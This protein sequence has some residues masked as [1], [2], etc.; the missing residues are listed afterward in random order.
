MDK[1]IKK[2]DYH[3]KEIYKLEIKLHKLKEELK[4]KNYDEDQRQVIQDNSDVILVEAYPGSGKTHTLLGRV[5]RIVDEDPTLLT[6]MVII[7]FTKKAGE[8]LCDKI[9]K[10]VPGGDPYFVGT[11]HGLAYRE[12]SSIFNK[13]LSLLDQTDEIKIIKDLS[14]S[15]VKKSLINSNLLPI[16]EKYGDMAYQVSSTRYPPNLKGFCEKNG[17]VEYLQDFKLLLEEYRKEKDRMELIDFNDLMTQFYLKL[18]E[19][20]LSKLEQIDYLF[21]DEYQDVNPIQNQILKELNSRGIHLMVVGDPRQSIYSFRGSEVT[22]I[23]NFKDDFP[24][25]KKFVL[26]YNY[27]S[28]KDIVNLVNDIFEESNMVAKNDK[29]KKPNVRVFSD[30]KLEKKYVIDKIVEK[31]NQGCDYKKMTILTRKNRILSQ[32]EADLLRRN[33]PYLKNGGVSLLERAH[34]KDLLSFMTILFYPKQTF[35]WKRIL[36]LHPNIGIKTTSKILSECKLPDDL[37]KYQYDKR[38]E[39]LFNLHQFI[40]KIKKFNL[41]EISMEITNYFED[42]GV[43]YNFPIE[44]RDNDFKALTQFLDNKETFNKFL[45]EIYLERTLSIPNNEDY[46]EI[47][48]FHGSKGLEWDVVFLM[49][50]SGSEI[51]HYRPSFFLE[52]NNAIEEERRL[53]FVACSRAKKELYLT[54]Y[55]NAP[56]KRDENVTPYLLELNNNLYEG[57]LLKNNI[58]PPKNITKLVD[59][60]LYEKGNK[61]IEPFLSNIKFKRIQITKKFNVPAYLQSHYL[62]FIVGNFFDLLI[63]RMSYDD[64]LVENKIWKDMIK[65]KA[66]NQDFSVSWKE[67]LSQFWFLAGGTKDSPWKEYLDNIETSKWDELSQD[68]NKFLM[69]EKISDIEIYPK[70]NY[71]GIFGEMDILNDKFIIEIKTCWGESLTLKHLLQVILYQF[72]YKN[73]NKNIKKVLIYNPLLGEG[74]W[75][76]KTSEW[77][78]ISEYIIKYYCQY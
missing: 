37:I 12:L 14:I 71:K 58:I 56:W 9:K 43:N 66:L 18:K 13:G 40:N 41:N 31:R 67:N 39:N 55:L 49:G 20:R 60:Y 64:V 32:L 62:P 73:Q 46:L 33:I 68:W 35:H 45:E 28:S 23:K 47:N 29:F 11:F 72:I 52:E 7:T 6:K 21:F 2:I 48:T 42:I 53:F 19:N 36:M 50:L 59:R 70:L 75:L 57:K 27:R 69:K 5:K 51:P 26:S 54:S 34:V 74:I 17:L 1:I 44:E 25:S 22:F 10:L 30:F 24:K 4:W 76:T 8:E 3:Q 63:T 65:E 16:L 78:K 15:L 61:E 38:F 77:K